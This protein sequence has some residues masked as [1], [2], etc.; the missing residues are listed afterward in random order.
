MDTQFEMHFEQNPL[1]S[2]D[3]ELLPFMFE[4]AEER[5]NADDRK[6]GC[7]TDWLTNDVNA[8]TD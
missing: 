6:L 4:L 5:E 3:K 8:D 1:A 2:E 7:E